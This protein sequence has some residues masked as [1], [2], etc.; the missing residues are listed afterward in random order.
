VILSSRLI[1]SDHNPVAQLTITSHLPNFGYDTAPSLNR[2][3]IRQPAFH[4]FVGDAQPA[5]LQ[6]PPSVEAG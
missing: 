3:T 6:P 4:Q 2:S 5:R 1:R